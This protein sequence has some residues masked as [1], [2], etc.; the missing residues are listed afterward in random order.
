M[1]V[2]AVHVLIRNLAVSTDASELRD[3][4]QS[5]ASTTTD[6][7]SDIVLSDNAAD[8]SS[9]CSQALLQCSDLETA[10]RIV[11]AIDG[12]N[13]SGVTIH[14]QIQQA[15]EPTTMQPTDETSNTSSS[16]TTE[17]VSRPVHRTEH[18]FDSRCSYV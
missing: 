6:S 5:L 1:A 16:M 12:E 2:A 14:A 4:V 8:G 7:I 18:R 15:T 10:E 3:W 11:A 13:F 9:S 17:E